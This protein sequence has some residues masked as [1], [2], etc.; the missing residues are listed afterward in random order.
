MT[1]TEDRVRSGFGALLHPRGVAV[2]G[3]SS[4]PG[5]LGWAMARSLD[6]F[7]GTVHLVNSVRA[8]PDRG[9]FESVDAAV[10]ATGA[11]ADLAVIC[12]PATATAEAIRSAAN[13][14]V[15][16]AILCAGGFSEAGPDGARLQAELS[17]VSRETGVRLVGPNTSGVI[18]PAVGLTASF[19]PGL[20]VVQDGSVAVVAASGGVNHALVFAM[21]NRGIGIRMAIGLGNSVDLDMADVLEALADDERTGV[22]ALHVESVR[23]GRRLVDAVSCLVER[24]PVVTSVVGRA[25]IA[26]FAQSHTGAL[27]APWRTTRAAL[28][29][30]GAVVVDDERALLD[31]VA[32]LSLTRLRRRSAPASVGIVTGQAGPGLLLVDAIRSSGVS[33]PPLSAATTKTLETLLPPMTFQQ[34]PVDTG[35]PGATFG[36]VVRAVSDD[37]AID[38]VL[39][40]ALVEPGAIDLAAVLEPFR[41]DST[42][43]VA[44]IGGPAADVALVQR[45]L[46]AVGIPAHDTPAAAAV[47]IKALVDDAWR[48][49]WS[50]RPIAPVVERIT[51]VGHRFDEAQAKAFLASIGIAV[52][53]NATC[54]SADEVRVA[55]RTFSGPVV[56]KILDADVLHKSEIGGVHVGITTDDDLE[57]AIA[58][59]QSI[60]TSRFLLEAMAPSGIDVLVGARRDP[61]FGPIVTVAVGGVY[62]ELI[63]DVAIRLA[64]LELD[65][66]TQMTSELR[67]AALFDG[68]CGKAPIDI[69]SLASAICCLGDVLV[70]DSGL[71]EIEIN[72]LRITDAGTM[73]ALDAVMLVREETHAG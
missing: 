48:T 31:A 18:V 67:M 33:V 57:A 55:F 45:Q 59:L 12:V 20:D 69:G 41:G 19:V 38:V 62:A 23:D 63:D 34:N 1:A 21:A 71:S 35:R 53:A 22:I 32:T 4:V 29:Q 2:I 73:L 24:V 56:L 27:A 65:A 58:A 30:A 37:E 6:R 17:S 7:P 44:A 16:I 25:D 9:V 54:E 70:N 28:R 60:G 14:G 42:P 10:R 68:W 72:P 50:S 26:D 47:G 61:S 40:Y 11:P 46:A 3:A 8:D 39:V 15:E 49:R 64:P 51:A 52:P 36:S 66:A 5:K 13:G 43:I